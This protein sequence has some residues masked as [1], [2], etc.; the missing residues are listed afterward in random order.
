[1]FE[2]VIQVVHS[3][4]KPGN[5]LDAMAVDVLYRL[6]PTIGI[7]PDDGENDCDGSQSQEKCNGLHLSRS[8]S[9]SSCDF[10]EKDVCLV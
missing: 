7:S 9:D 4:C 10:V 1:M 8:V 6:P 3:Y 5:L 2:T